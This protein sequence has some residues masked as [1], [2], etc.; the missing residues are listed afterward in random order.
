MLLVGLV[1]GLVGVGIAVAPPGDYTCGSSV[2]AAFRASERLTYSAGSSVGRTVPPSA[3]PSTSSTVPADGWSVVVGTATPIV[4]G[5]NHC[6]DAARAQVLIG[7]LVLLL[8]GIGSGAGWLLL[9][10]PSSAGEPS[11]SA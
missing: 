8:A 5:A 3:A 1:V 6:R 9:R 7:L 2:I 10:Q 4:F 11:I